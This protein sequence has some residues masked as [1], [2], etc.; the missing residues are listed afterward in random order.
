MKKFWLL[1]WQKEVPQIM[2]SVF[3]CSMLVTTFAASISILQLPEAIQSAYYARSRSAFHWLFVLGLPA[4]ISIVT[5]A[6]IMIRAVMRERDNW[7]P[8]R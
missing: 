8:L 6:I 4:T 1:V 3:L 7:R 5:G 2:V